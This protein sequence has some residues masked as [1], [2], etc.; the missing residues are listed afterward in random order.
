MTPLWTPNPKTV[1]PVRVCPVCGGKSRT[2]A[3]YPD[4][5]RY[6]SL[7]RVCCCDQEEPPP[8]FCESCETTIDPI[9]SVR[10]TLSGV[11]GSRCTECLQLVT[12]FYR[13]NS[14]SVDGAYTVPEYRAC[15]TLGS[16]YFHKDYQYRTAVRG[17]F[18][19]YQEYGNFNTPCDTPEGV[20]FWPWVDDG[21]GDEGFIDVALTCWN[22]TIMVSNLLVWSQG[23]GPSGSEDGRF[24]DAAI[25]RDN[26]ATYFDLNTNI[27]NA[28][29]ACR[30]NESPSYLT[31]SNG[32]TARVEII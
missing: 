21:T 6:M 30:G 2:L 13:I 29:G 32:G 31:G 9:A 18:G 12:R 27:P 26:P 3:A 8:G 1:K 24:F 17:D 4:T 5:R 19:E 11:D 14:V 16:I 20:F 23:F 22:N 25:D 28:I 15:N 7:H 10:V